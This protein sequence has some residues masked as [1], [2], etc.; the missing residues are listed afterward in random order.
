MVLAGVYA[1]CT[2]LVTYVSVGDK[3]Q[4]ILHSAHVHINTHQ[5]FVARMTRMLS[6]GY[7]KWFE[8]AYP[9]DSG[10]RANSN[11]HI[12]TQAGQL[13]VKLSEKIIKEL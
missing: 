1:S 8:S 12:C 11:L 3:L 5:L 9:L 7:L 4:R 13:I 10:H 2:Y 6:S